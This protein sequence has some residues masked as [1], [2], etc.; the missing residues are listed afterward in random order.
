VLTGAKSTTYRT[1]GSSFEH[2]NSES[3]AGAANSGWPPSPVM[4]RTE[5][6]VLVVVCARESRVHGEGGQ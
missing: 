2:G 1:M 5:D 6:G 3:S 4:S